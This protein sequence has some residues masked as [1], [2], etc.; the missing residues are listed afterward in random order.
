MTTENTVQTWLEGMAESNQSTMADSAKMQN[1]L[2][3][4]GFPKTV[5]VS[6]IVYLEGR[7]TM[8]A[9]PASIHS[10]AKMLAKITASPYSPN[11]A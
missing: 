1:L 4:V 7:G 11:G 6:G 10:V 2:R 8:Q 9:P 5:V 3:R